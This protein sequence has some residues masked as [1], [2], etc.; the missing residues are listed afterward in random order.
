[1]NSKVSKKKLIIKPKIEKNP[2]KKKKV[3]IF[4]KKSLK[5]L[6]SEKPIKATKKKKLVIKP[7]KS[8]NKKQL[9]IDELTIIKSGEA[10]KKDRW[11]TVAYN[12]AIKALKEYDGKFTRSEDVKHLNGIGAKILKKIDEILAT[13]KLKAANVIRKDKTISAVEILSKIA[14]IGPVK[15][16]ELVEKHKIKSLEMLRKK[17]KT[18]QSL[19]NDKQK[20]G[21]KHYEDLLKKIPRLEIDKHKLYLQKK[22]LELDKDLEISIVGSYRRGVKSSGD[23]DVLLRH[24]KDKNL[25]KPYVEMLKKDKYIQDVLSLGSKKH[26]GV[27]LLKGHKASRRI[28]ILHTT[29]ME[30]PFALLYFTGSGTFNVEVRK[31]ATDMGYKLNEYGLKKKNENNYFFKAKNEKEIFK[32]LKIKYLEPEKRYPNNIINV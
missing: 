18:N 6:K 3:L 15:A 5:S 27:C 16:R 24:K 13:G 7:K 29:K 14:A 19:L 28:D 10:F 21:L 9:V 8:I 32:F 25:I 22:A 20:I 12:K 17:I 26:G 30:Y 11:R 1:M 23:I 4:K 31:K 2:S